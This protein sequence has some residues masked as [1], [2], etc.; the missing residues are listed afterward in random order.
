MKR[1]HSREAA[2]IA[3]G[4][5]LAIVTWLWPQEQVPSGLRAPLLVTG[6]AIL[7]ASLSSWALAAKPESE[8]QMPGDDGKNINISSTNQTGGFTGIL[9]QQGSVRRQL[10]DRL[11]SQLLTKL[12]KGKVGV[13]AVMGVA[14]GDSLGREIAGF[15]A[16]Q[17]Y[18][19]EH[20]GSM[21]LNGAPPGISIQ[22]FEDTPS[23]FINHP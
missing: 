3:L 10:D 1:T 2:G 23:V 11:K 21:M 20:F 17:G 9:I 7:L 12:P 6:I 16:S 15:L 14:D 13:M 19:I 5:G 22:M 8:N 18:T 4:V